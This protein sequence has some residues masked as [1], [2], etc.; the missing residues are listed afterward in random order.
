MFYY[1]YACTYIYIYIYAYTSSKPSPTRAQ[2]RLGDLHR[3]PESDLKAWLR[4][5]GSEGFR[6]L[7][8]GVLGLG[9]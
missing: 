1:M 3:A 9:P 4:V 8:F 5:L 2:S 6:T 7:G